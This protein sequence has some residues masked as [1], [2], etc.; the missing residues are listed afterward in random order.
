M[1]RLWPFAICLAIT[2]GAMAQGDQASWTWHEKLARGD[3]LDVDLIRGEVFIEAG[4]K[5][6]VRIVPRLGLLPAAVHYSVERRGAVVTIRDH[7]PGRFVPARECLPPD[8][9]R[10]DFAA[11]DTRLATT[12]TIQPGRRLRVH[13]MSGDIHVRVAG[14][15][16]L[17]TN[18][19]RIIGGA[20]R[21]PR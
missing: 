12:I 14:D 18:R 8:R 2:S 7:Y 20:D 10:G 17:S 21:R 5:S 19:G 11:T 15:F 1:K 4:A 16:D 9:E 13:L 3:E 6:G